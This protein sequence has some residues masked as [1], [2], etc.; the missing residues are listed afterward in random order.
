MYVRGGSNIG[1]Q[2]LW[3]KYPDA[4]SWMKALEFGGLKVPDEMDVITLLQSGIKFR[5]KCVNTDLDRR[6]RR[7]N[8]TLIGTQR[9]KKC[10]G[11]GTEDFFG[12]GN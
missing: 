4:I 10:F 11:C 5:M 9:R 12:L 7:K 1:A 3:G 6:E 2:K 8:S